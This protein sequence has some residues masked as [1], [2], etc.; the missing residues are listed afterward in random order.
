ML[1]IHIDYYIT[2]SEVMSVLVQLKN[3]ILHPSCL[4]DISYKRLSTII[5][6]VPPYRIIVVS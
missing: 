2:L 3:Y 1:T 6:I 4:L 5:K